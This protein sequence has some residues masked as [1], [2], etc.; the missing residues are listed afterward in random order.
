MSRR[1]RAYSPAETIVD[2]RPKRA[3]Q[4]VGEGTGQVVCGL[5]QRS[6]S[7]EVY[8]CESRG[9]IMNRTPLPKRKNEGV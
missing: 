2:V 9:R 7:A 6:E 5:R 3:V 1:G 8:K 4:G